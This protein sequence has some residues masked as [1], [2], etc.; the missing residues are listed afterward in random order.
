MYAIYTTPGFIVGSKPHGEAG[1]VLF[2]FTRDFGLITAVAAGIRLE[3]SKLRY[4]VQ[5]YSFGIFSLVKGK[6]FWRLTSVG[7]SRKELV[8]GIESADAPINS[9]K[10]SFGDQLVARLAL[11]L[12]RLLHGEE[13]NP[14]LF[15]S[16]E[17]AISFI[18]SSS[19]LDDE[20]FKTLESLAVYR[21][22]ESLGYIGKDNFIDLEV[23]EEILSVELL[24]SIQ[25]KRG[26][27][28]KHINK[29]LR[30]SHL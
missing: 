16:V 9:K 4:G 6:E 17:S 25:E 13:A 5:D 21:M 22:L 1:K 27:L 20:R 24:D 26:V 10:R 15:S 11:L 28:N 7:D 30:E 14:A 2:I 12:R 23:R 19:S 18:C 8:L 3:R 29:A